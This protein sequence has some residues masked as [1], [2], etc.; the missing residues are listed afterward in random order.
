[1][2]RGLILG[3][4]L[5]LVAGVS[6][7]SAQ[8]IKWG[9]GGGMIMPQGNA[10][11]STDVDY[12][13][14]DKSGFG[15]GVNV[16]F[17]LS[18]A[19]LGVRVDGLY[20]TTNHKDSF[21]NNLAGTSSCGSSTLLGANADLVYNFKLGGA[22]TPYVQGG[23]GF[24][25]QKVKFE[26]SGV[27]VD[28]SKANFAYNLGAGIDWKLSSVTLFL[29]ARYVISKWNDFFGTTGY[30]ANVNFIPLMVGVRFGGK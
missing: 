5:A 11:T 29:D 27:S 12:G 14:I 6:S 1:M 15:G 23:L 10:N 7:L 20:G 22:I 28:S 30:T 8:G 13:Y 26:A 24:Y 3:L 16:T 9:V 18:V 2:K 4:A 25:D 21:C 19:G 17:P